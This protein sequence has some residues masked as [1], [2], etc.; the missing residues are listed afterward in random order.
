VNI[1]ILLFA[2]RNNQKIP[3]KIIIPA[4]DLIKTRKSNVSPN[5]GLIPEKYINFAIKRLI[6]EKNLFK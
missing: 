6:I 3:G 2:L 4:K 5:V 1:L